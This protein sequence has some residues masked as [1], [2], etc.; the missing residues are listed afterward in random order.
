MCLKQRKSMAMNIIRSNRQTGPYVKLSRLIL[1]MEFAENHRNTLSEKY[2]CIIFSTTKI[3]FLDSQINGAVFMIQRTYGFISL[4]KVLTQQKS[5]ATAALNLASICT[6]GVIV[7][8]MGLEKTLLALLF[9][10]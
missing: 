2:K 9:I 6:K 3:T 10:G 7:D 4:P 5:V 1:E 8:T